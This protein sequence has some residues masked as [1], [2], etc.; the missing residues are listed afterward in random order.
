MEMR[1]DLEPPAK[2]KESV[3]DAVRVARRAVV[4]S[5]REGERRSVRG[6]SQLSHAFGV[7]VPE[8]REA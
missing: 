1:L 8:L 6:E 2:P 5:V 3:C 7:L 4:S